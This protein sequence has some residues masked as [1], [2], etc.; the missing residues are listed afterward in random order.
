MED[1]NL[2]ANQCCR[3]TRAIVI[4]ATTRATRW[5]VVALTRIRRPDT[6]S[7]KLVIRS[8]RLRYFQ[9]HHRFLKHVQPITRFPWKILIRKHDL[10][11]IWEFTVYK[12]SVWI[13]LWHQIPLLIALFSAILCLALDAKVVTKVS[14]WECTHILSAEL[15]GTALHS[16]HTRWVSIPFCLQSRSPSLV[17][18]S[19]RLI[20][21]LFHW[22]THEYCFLLPSLG[23]DQPTL[24]CLFGL[25]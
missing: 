17:R 19:S 6:W 10:S 23:V 18:T 4:V 13:K 24:F 15:Q 14:F 21:H 20:S 2:S 5:D 3:Q 8:S 16:Q 9:T 11:R 25:S 7:I 12:N 1:V 22:F